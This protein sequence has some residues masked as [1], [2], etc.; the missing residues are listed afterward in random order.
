MIK[1]HEIFDRD[2]LR[3]R[4]N[5]AAPQAEA[6]D[7]LMQRAAEDLFERLLL[8]NRPF[9]LALN[10][11]AHTGLLSEKVRQLPGIDLIIDMERSEGLLW[12]SRGTRVLAD[13]EALPFRDGS[14]DLVVSALAI[15][16]INDLPGTLVQ[17]R[18]ALKPDGLFLAAMLGGETL[19]ELREAW[20][21]AESEIED[22]ASPRVTPFADVRELGSLLQ[23]AGFALP[24]T[25]TERLTVT[26]PNP[27]ALMAEL[28]AMGASNA[29][30]A[31]RRKP[32][33]RRLINRAAE[34]YVERFSVPGGR[35]RATFE[36]ITLTAWAP[37][38]SQQTP[39]KPGS[40]K[41]RLAD[42]LGSLE[43]AVPRDDP[44]TPKG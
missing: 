9:R 13:E 12:R 10:L 23:R 30:A 33:T 44:P 18:R 28:K 36:V 7:F 17:I 38:E 19:N 22:G 3:R 26:Y 37:H 27:F 41:H 31:R 6:T 29:L 16:Y 8:V 43:Q 4:R 1:E 15:Q 35:I 2:L 42:A 40:A 20:L 34:A 21:V 14:I 24:V 32:V 5:R 39:L 25:D 11:G